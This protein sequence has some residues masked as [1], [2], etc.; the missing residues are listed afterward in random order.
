MSVIHFLNVKEGD[1]IWIKHNSEHNTIIDVSN[2]KTINKI[3][4]SKMENLR[5]KSIQ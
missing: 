2:A 3:T 1:C 4:E 5:E